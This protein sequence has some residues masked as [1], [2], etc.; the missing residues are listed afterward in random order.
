MDN[1]LRQVPVI[2]DQGRTPGTAGPTTFRAW[3]EEVLRRAVQS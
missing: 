3:C 2:R 1:V